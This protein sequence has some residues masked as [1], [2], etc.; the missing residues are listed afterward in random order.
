MAMGM[1]ARDSRQ[2]QA[3]FTL[4][5]LIFV[6]CILMLLAGILLPRLARTNGRPGRVLCVNQ[7]KNI[8]LAFRTFASDNSSQFPMAL[9]TE[10]GGSSNYLGTPN[11]LPH[12][13]SLSNELSTVDSLRCP[14]YTK[15][16]YRRLNWATV[17][18]KNLDYFVGV[19]AL[20]DNPA[21]IVS[22]DRF[23][24]SDAPYSNYVV[25]LIANSSVQWLPKPHPNSGNVVFSDGHVEPIPSTEWTNRIRAS[26]L[27]VM[28]LAVPQYVPTK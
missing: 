27:Q 28:R 17:A 3:A 19:N 1:L 12:F 18:E 4:L 16:D 13:K 21:H 9:A 14:L 2:R 22:G 15:S 23:L 26:G 8:G 25:N 24:K 6:F 11:I 20:A 5:D 10:N 7:L